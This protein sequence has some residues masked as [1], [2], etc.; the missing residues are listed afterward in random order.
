MRY[1]DTSVI[2]AFYL[3]ERISAK[4]QK[5]F[6]AIDVVAI[7][8]LSEV[9]LCS[10]ISRRVRT[11]ELS[12][13]DAMKVISRFRVHIDDGLYEIVP[14]T[15]RAYALARDWLA[16]FQTPLRTLDALHLAVAFGGDSTLVSAD[17]EL[18]HS[19]RYCGVKHELV[20]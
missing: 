11:R 12:I 6:A 10:A 13:G 16:S 5:L 8:P 3:P 9:E 7:S 1:I 18:V 15:P 4:V 2:V 19:A 14:V 17:R 20:S